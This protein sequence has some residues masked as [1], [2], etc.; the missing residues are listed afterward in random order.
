MKNNN[1]KM[2]NYF[3]SAFTSKLNDEYKGKTSLDII[4]NLTEFKKYMPFN[5]KLNNKLIVLK[6]IERN[7]MNSN[8]NIKNSLT[9]NNSSL[10]E[11]PS[12]ENILNNKNMLTNIKKELINKNNIMIPRN[13]ETVNNQINNNL[14]T[15]I[16]YINTNLKNKINLPLNIIGQPALN[17]SNINYLSLITKFNPE[18]AKV[19]NTLFNFNLTN[20]KLLRNVYTILE[21]SFKSMSSLISKPYLYIN[22]DKII[23]HL[24]F[25]KKV[26]PKFNLYK[27]EWNIK[28]IKANQKLPFLTLNKTK[29]ENLC[30][31]LSKIFNKSVELELTQLHHPY[32]EPN[33]LVNALGSI[34][35]KIKLRKILNKLFKAVVIKNPTRM[36]N[37][38]RFSS[39]PCLLSGLSIKVAGR[40][41][42]Q[43]VVPRKTVKFIQKGSLSRTKS[44]FVENARFTNKNKRGSFSLTV[45]SGYF[46]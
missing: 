33:I 18:V 31:L 8:N 43:R 3:E 19:K 22:Q 4:T 28:E 9:L 15:R 17:E 26:L 45:T 41:M 37:R 46:L 12:N 16:N 36:I 29:L 34:V 30:A 21:Y 14:I 40:V 2:L 7:L 11:T 1:I 24:F 39:V 23:I 38:K 5:T 32:H 27:N 20:N 6:K 10:I 42:T 13:K 35:N 44:I 25:Y